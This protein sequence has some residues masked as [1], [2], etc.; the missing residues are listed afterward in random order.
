MFRA[1]LPDGAI[2]CAEY[3]LGEQGVDLLTES[4]ELIAFVPYANLVALVNEEFESGEDRA[5]F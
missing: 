1:I 3:D 5:I 2:E 4:G